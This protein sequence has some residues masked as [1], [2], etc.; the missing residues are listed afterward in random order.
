M[1]RD[2]LFYEAVNEVNEKRKLELAYDVYFANLGI[3]VEMMNSLHVRSSLRDDFLQV[4]Y[5]A[6]VK[7][8]QSYDKTSGFSTL[9]YY[10]MCVKHEGYL[11][12]RKYMNEYLEEE[13]SL[14]AELLKS[15]NYKKMYSIDDGVIK[16]FMNEFL[17]ERLHIILSEEDAA[18]VELRYLEKQTLKKIGEIYG[19]S[20]ER[21]RQRLILSYNK[22]KVDQGVREV[23]CFYNYKV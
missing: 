8:I 15:G 21:V 20:A 17:W 12:W 2:D 6:M 22:L 3:T 18:I 11:L 10:R 14:D 7:S 13:S 4:A 9:S 16:L 5:L 23:A 1:Y 19:I